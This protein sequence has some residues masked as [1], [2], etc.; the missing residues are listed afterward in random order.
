MVHEE[1]TEL[2]IGSAIAVHRHL[3]PGLLDSAYRRGLLHELGLRGSP[4]AREVASDLEYRGLVVPACS[5]LYLGVAAKVVVEV[6]TVD[7]I[8]GIHTAQLLTYLKLTSR[9]VGLLL[10]FKVP[11]L[12]QGVARVLL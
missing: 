6:K 1:L 10:T 3:G 2:I 4:A 12:R 8:A 11:V 5:G 7:P 9:R